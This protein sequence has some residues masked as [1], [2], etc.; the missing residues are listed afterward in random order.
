MFKLLLIIEVIFKTLFVIAEIAAIFCMWVF[1]VAL[2]TVFQ[3]N[4]LPDF[5]DIEVSNSG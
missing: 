4:E 3:K 5:E 2:F 1:I